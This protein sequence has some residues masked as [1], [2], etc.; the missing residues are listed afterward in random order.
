MFSP[1]SAVALLFIL[2]RL[3]M[4]LTRPFFGLQHGLHYLLYFG[5]NCWAQGVRSCR[6]R[7][8]LWFSFPFFSWLPHP[9]FLPIF[10]EFSPSVVSFRVSSSN[11]W[12]PF[13]IIVFGTLALGFLA[14]MLIL[15][16]SLVLVHILRVLH[17]FQEILHSFHF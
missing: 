15:L 11:S 7:R 14:I 5:L 1:E 9:C 3:L 4:M 17:M 6:N 10:F 12:I 13:F 8:S 2:P 16:V